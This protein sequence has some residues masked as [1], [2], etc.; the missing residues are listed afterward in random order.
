VGSA[1]PPLSE[2]PAHVLGLEVVAEGVET[3]TQ[4]EY[5]RDR[6]CDFAQGYLFNRPM[7]TADLSAL[8]EKHRLTVAV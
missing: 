8:L 7:A 6:A 2:K 1:A 5:L 3:A 4:A